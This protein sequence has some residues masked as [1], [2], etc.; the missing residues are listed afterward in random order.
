MNVQISAPRNVASYLAA[1]AASVLIGSS[2]FA[3]DRS[4][5]ATNGMVV[6]GHP[7]A[8]QAGLKV[9]QAGGTACDAAVATATVLSITLTDMMGPAGSGYALLWDPQKKELSSID[10]NGVA[11]AATDPAKFDMAKKLRG[12]MAP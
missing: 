3:L 1:I 10:Y 6:A 8:A 7:L 12:P 11:P 4:V 2:A 5:I 9:L